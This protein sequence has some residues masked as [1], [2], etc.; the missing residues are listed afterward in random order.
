MKINENQWKFWI[1]FVLQMRWR[2]PSRPLAHAQTASV[3]S[4]EVRCDG[5]W[6]DLRVGADQVGAGQGSSIGLMGNRQKCPKIIKINGNWWFLMIFYK[7]YIYKICSPHIQPHTHTHGWL[8]VPSPSPSPGRSV[9]TLGASIID[10]PSIYDDLPA[11]VT[12]RPSRWTG[13][14]SWF[15]FFSK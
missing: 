1:L 12:L 14:K 13:T 5:M 6:H 9:N 7:F 2:H 3:R 15:S 10:K 11:L 8:Q 4:R